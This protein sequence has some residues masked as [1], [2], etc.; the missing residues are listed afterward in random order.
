MHDCNRPSSFL[1]RPVLA[2]LSA[3]I[4]P[5]VQTELVA[6]IDQLLADPVPCVDSARRLREVVLRRFSQQAMQ[7]RFEQTLSEIGL[8]TRRPSLA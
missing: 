1:V 7:R 6:R 5:L 8:L 3:K 2:R 4:A